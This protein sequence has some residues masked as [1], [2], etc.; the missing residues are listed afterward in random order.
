LICLFSKFFIFLF[1]F[2]E[3]FSG[4]LKLF[5]ENVELLLFLLEMGL[6]LF[7]GDVVLFVDV[8]DIDDVCFVGMCEL[9]LLLELGYFMLEVLF[10]GFDGDEDLTLLFIFD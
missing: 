7:E 6:F 5:G 1:I 8:I 4:G 9:E 2:D 10:I 3:G